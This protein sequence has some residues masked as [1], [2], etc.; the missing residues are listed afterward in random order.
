MMRVLVL[1]EDG[2]GDDA[3]IAGAGFPLVA[4]VPVFLGSLAC[5]GI[6]FA[7]LPGGRND[8]G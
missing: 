1:V 5:K 7:G 2:T 8:A 4:A 6:A 3:A